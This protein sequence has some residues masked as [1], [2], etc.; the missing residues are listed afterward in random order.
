M[1]GVYRKA[2]AICQTTECSFIRGC[3]HNHNASTAPAKDPIPIK[4]TLPDGKVV[5]GKAWRTSPY[6]IA[7]RSGL[8]ILYGFS[9]FTML[10]PFTATQLQRKTLSLQ[11]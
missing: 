9:G 2:M 10:F 5:D 7:C 3:S 4:V 8:I 11:R 6:D 1:Q